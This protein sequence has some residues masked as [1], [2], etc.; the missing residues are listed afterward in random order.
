MRGSIMGHLQLMHKWKHLK[1]SDMTTELLHCCHFFGKL[2]PKQMYN[3]KAL[4]DIDI[5]IKET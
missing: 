2:Q 4:S 5:A 1:V 3:L